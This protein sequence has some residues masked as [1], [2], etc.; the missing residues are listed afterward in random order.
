M[1][2]GNADW[3]GA[4]MGNEIS[5]CKLYRYFIKKLRDERMANFDDKS[6]IRVF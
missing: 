1:A 4:S 6:R 2:N 3:Q 5:D